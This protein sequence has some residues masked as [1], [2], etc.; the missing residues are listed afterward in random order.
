MYYEGGKTATI[1]CTDK[2][3]DVILKELTAIAGKL[4][5][6]YI[7][8]LCV[9]IVYYYRTQVKREADTHKRNPATFGDK[10]QGHYC[11]CTMPGQ[12]PC[13]AIV[14]R[15]VEHTWKCKDKTF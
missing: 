3:N 8:F 14:P 10:R 11:I 2:E 4:E 7:G 12:V 1:D 6:V 15:K 13:T 9:G 5:Y